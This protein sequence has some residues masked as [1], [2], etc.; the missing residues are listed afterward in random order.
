[1]LTLN[2]YTEKWRNIK[3]INQNVINQTVFKN[4]EQFN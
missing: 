1:M 4:F 2:I 3:I